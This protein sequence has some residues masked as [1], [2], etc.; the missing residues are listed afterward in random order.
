MPALRKPSADAVRA[1]LAAQAGLPFTYPDVGATA[2]DP[3]A[4]WTVDRTR[5][6]VGTGEG[7]FIA[8][9]A[10]LARWEQ[11]DLGWV[12]AAPAGVPLAEGACV[13]VVA[14]VLGLWWLNACRVVY[15]VDEPCR[16]GFAYGTLPGHA[17]RGEERFLVE[18]DRGVGRGELRHRGVLAPRNPLA[19]ARATR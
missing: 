14:R 13:A 19:A 6:R 17:E 9:K 1:F 15:T 11:F 4:G 10:A 5:A 16:F 2:A 18:W 12:E 8:A 7:A 3:P